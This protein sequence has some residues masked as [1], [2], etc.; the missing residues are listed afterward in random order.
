MIDFTNQDLNSVVVPDEK[1]QKK[2]KATLSIGHLKTLWHKFQAEHEEK[3]SYQ[4]N[5]AS[6]CHQTSLSHDLK[7]WVR[8]CV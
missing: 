2:E 5:S 6:M 8:V 7:T 4:Q 1:K 3:I